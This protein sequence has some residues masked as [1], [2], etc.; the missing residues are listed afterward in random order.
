MKM[1]SK[2]I[3]C[4]PELRETFKK[5]LD[6]EKWANGTSWAVPLIPSK[7]RDQLSTM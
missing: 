4:L 7:I 5:A 1:G 2:G 6:Y 3:K